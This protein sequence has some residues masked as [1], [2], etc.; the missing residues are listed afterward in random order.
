MSNTPP[1]SKV[2]ILGASDNPERYARQAFQFLRQRNFV[3]IPVNPRISTIE[4]IPV[5]PSLKE[6][7][8]AVDTVTLYVNPTLVEENL[9]DLITLHPRRVIMNPGTEH[10]VAK[11]RL[12]EAGIEVELACTLVL[13]KTGQF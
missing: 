9:E 5:I 11:K 7:T 1:G 6:V 4:D 3:P 13:L 8:G 10:L 2:V 12:E